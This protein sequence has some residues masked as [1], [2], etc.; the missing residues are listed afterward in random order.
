MTP[1]LLNMNEPPIEEE[2]KPNLLF[3]YDKAKIQIDQIIGQFGT[4]INDA[5]V[6]RDERYVELDISDL[7]DKGQIAPDET[8]IPDRIIDSNIKMDVADCMS[9]L[10]SGERLA[11]FQCLSD[12]TIDTRELEKQFTNGLTYRGWFREF[13]RVADGAATHGVDY[14]EVVFDETKPLHIGFEHVGYDRLYFNDKVEDIQDSELLIR[15]YKTPISK[16]EEFE[17]NFNFDSGVVDVI[18]EAHKELRRTEIV[19]IYRVFFK[20]GGIVYIAWYYK[21]SKVSTWLKVPEQLRL[22]LYTQEDQP[23]PIT[24]IPSKVFVEMPITQYPIFSYL[25]CDDEQSPLLDHKGRGFLDGP[26]QEA[27]TAIITS[28]VNSCVK[29]TSIY[30]SPANVDSETVEMKQLDLQL[31]P[32]GV[33]NNPLEFWSKPY[34]EATML[35]SVNLLDT[36]NANQRGKTAYSVKNR[37]DSRK[38][39]KELDVAENQQDLIKGTTTAG[40]SEFLRGALEFSWP[41]VQSQALMGS[42]KFMLVLAPVDPNFPNSVSYINDN[43]LISQDFDIRPA[44][45]IDVVQAQQEQQ[46]MQQDWPVFQLT[47]LK[48]KFLEDYV[49]VRY[50]KKAKEYIAAL[51]A[52]NQTKQLVSALSTSLT[53][54]LNPEEIASL[55]PQEKQNLDSI[56]Q[57]AQQFIQTP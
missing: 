2:V 22:G 5:I 25:Y 32:N 42:I 12:P 8:F 40:W 46:K 44:G 51:Q 45:D 50:P 27:T 35:S 1:D 19:N 26:Q 56:Q 7:R 30:A 24:G 20:D 54:A 53:G 15:L 11:I 29:A 18:T 17:A 21:D 28:Y 48:D 55:G 52:A 6:T 47:G 39:A 36:R 4:R 3:D 10:N 16:L 23:D 57:A 41:I 9:F 33:Y 34:P 37:V 13:L 43:S 49:S 31:V 38:T 14:I